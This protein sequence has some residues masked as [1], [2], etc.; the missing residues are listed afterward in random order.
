MIVIYMIYIS[1][2]LVQIRHAYDLARQKQSNLALTMEYRGMW[3]S[4]TLAATGILVSSAMP[5]E[6]VVATIT[7]ASSPNTPRKSLCS[8]FSPDA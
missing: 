5:L 1:C 8:S 7:L 4:V 3:N 6:L 2:Y